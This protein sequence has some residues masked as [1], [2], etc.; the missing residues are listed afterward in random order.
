MSARNARAKS[1]VRKGRFEASWTTGE[2]A[3]LR[4]LA[5]TLSLEEL[6]AEL[7]RSTGSIRGAAHRHAIS[8]RRTGERRGRILG[9]PAGVRL[10]SGEDALTRLEAWRRLREDVLAG[11]VDTGRIERRV[12]AA[13]RGEDLCPLCARRPVEVNRT[14]LCEV[15]HLTE[16]AR[17]HRDEL[18]R[19]EAARENDAARALTYR[20]RKR[21]RE[22][23]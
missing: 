18:E 12:R 5:G 23:S 1:R 6:A 7:G 14:G 10:I 4:R 21:G 8:L 3:R 13:L 19:I 22:A 11:R 2:I 15:C 20:A 9:Q 16:L 17:G